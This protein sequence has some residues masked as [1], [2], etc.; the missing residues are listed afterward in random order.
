MDSYEVTQTR[1]REID[2]ECQA[3]LGRLEALLR[4]IERIRTAL[5]DAQEEIAG[6]WTSELPRRNQ[7]LLD[8]IIRLR[9]RRLEGTLRQLKDEAASFAPPARLPYCARWWE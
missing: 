1:L 5:A 7:L 6:V 3:H 9:C 8:Q 4:E 2:Q